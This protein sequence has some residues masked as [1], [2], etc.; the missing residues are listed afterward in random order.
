MFK[1]KKNKQYKL[2]NIL[3]IIFIFI[4]LPILRTYFK[5]ILPPKI[6]FIKPTVKFGFGALCHETSILYPIKD[7]RISHIIR[8]WVLPFSKMPCYGG[9]FLLTSRPDQIQD[10]K[11]PQIVTG[12]CPFPKVYDEHVYSVPYYKMTLGKILYNPRAGREC[13]FR[14]FAFWSH[15]ISNTTLLWALRGGDDSFMNINNLHLLVQY[16]QDRPDPLT[17]MVLFGN[18][19]DVEG[20][21]CVQGGSGLMVSRCLMRYF[22]SFAEEMLRTQ[23]FWDDWTIPHTAIKFGMSSFEMGAPFFIGTDDI[24]F[25]DLIKKKKFPPCSEYALQRTKCGSIGPVPFS[26]LVMLHNGR[27]STQ[28]I[29]DFTKTNMS[30]YGFIAIYPLTVC[31]YI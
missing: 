1:H 3:I 27:E 31:E 15:I 21:M 26:S 16:L 5:K 20:Y 11:I 2:K 4:F 23:L 28:I 9:F 7:N 18:C 14:S 25:T 10:I 13:L 22:L 8:E 30:R 6:S 19:F 17:H 29:R 24:C 12:W